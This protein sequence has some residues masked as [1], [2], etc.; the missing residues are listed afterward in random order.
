M[1]GRAHCQCQD[2]FFLNYWNKTFQKKYCS[3]TQFGLSRLVCL[4]VSN[5]DF[6]SQMEGHCCF[7]LDIISHSP[8]IEMSS[9]F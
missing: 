2:V 8:K 9:L 7:N 3:K 5:V 6:I 1:T 4:S